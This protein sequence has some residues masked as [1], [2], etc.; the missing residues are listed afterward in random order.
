VPMIRHL[1]G[2]PPARATPSL[3]AR[4]TA[5]IPSEAGRTDYQPVRW[6]LREGE[7]F[8]EPVF[9]KSNLIFTLVRAGGVV[10]VPPEVTG[11]SA[12]SVVDVMLFDSWQGTGSDT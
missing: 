7:V 9:G 1:L 12:G 10:R 2:L 6:E 5:S 11:L 8:A 4:L 3:R